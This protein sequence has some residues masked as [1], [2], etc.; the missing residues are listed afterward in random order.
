[1]QELNRLQPAMSPQSYKTYAVA[2]PRATHWRDATCAE[3]DC[4]MYANGWRTVVDAGSEADVYIRADRSRRHVAEV[5]PD[6]QVAFTFEAG[7]ACF[8]QHRVKREIPELFV[9]RDGD[10][11]WSRN[12]VRRT[13]EDWVDD[14]RTHQDRLADRLKQG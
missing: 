9:V 6:G 14:F 5:L 3:A 7:Q 11:R 13:P 12:A 8:A 10:W 1:V 4:P 2:A